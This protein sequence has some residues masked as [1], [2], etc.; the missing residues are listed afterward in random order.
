MTCLK[1][2]LAFQNGGIIHLTNKVHKEIPNEGIIAMAHVKQLLLM[3]KE[4]DLFLF[5]KSADFIIPAFKNP[6]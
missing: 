6:L 2:Y 3:S 1:N 5:F 4:T